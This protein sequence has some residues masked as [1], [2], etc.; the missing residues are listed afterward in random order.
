[1]KRLSRLRW[2]RWA[3]SSWLSTEVIQCCAV[4]VTTVPCRSFQRCSRSSLLIVRA[5]WIA[6]ATWRAFHGLTPMQ[7]RS[8]E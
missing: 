5:R 4:W 8:V 6:C 3:R 2:F 1:M 7:A